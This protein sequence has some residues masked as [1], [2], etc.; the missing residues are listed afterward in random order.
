M[1][2][3]EGLLPRRERGEHRARSAPSSASSCSRLRCVATVV[4]HAGERLDAALELQ[5]R[6]F[7]GVL[8]HLHAPEI[9]EAARIARQA[10]GWKSR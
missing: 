7:E 3:D 6:F 10:R 8:V 9:V 5:D 4:A 1:A 2:G